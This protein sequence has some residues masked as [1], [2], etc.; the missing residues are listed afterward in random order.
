MG[1]EEERRYLVDRAVCDALLDALSGRLRPEIRHEA[2][3]FAFVRTT[4]LDT[5][6]WD[7]LCSREG[8]ARRRV[9][10]RQYGFAATEEAKPIFDGLA[11]LEL[12]RSLGRRR[13]K[14]RLQ[15][16]ATDL[17]HLL[18]TRLERPRALARRLEG[19]RPFWPIL[20]DLREGVLRP[21]VTTL[22]RRTSFI[23][24]VGGVRVTVDEAI[25][26]YRP[27]ALDL[28]LVEE[29]RFLA[30][31]GPVI[32]VKY[33]PPCPRWLRGQLASLPEVVDFSK[34]KMAA[35]ALRPH[36]A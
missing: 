31:R 8:A 13:K 9:R 4:Y 18:E 7:L 28:P 22:Y 14:V 34:F 5:D 16:H 11:F 2:W 36:G 26:A 19:L 35:E 15:A 30:V 20:G 25:A 12:K 32:E 17:A 33:H 27:A 3:P 6:A 23:D 24:A 1:I 29:Q 10:L 21:R